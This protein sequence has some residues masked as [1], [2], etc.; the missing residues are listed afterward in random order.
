VHSH[1]IGHDNQAGRKYTFTDDELQYLDDHCVL[2]IH[3]KSTWERRIMLSVAAVS[4]SSGA[5]SYFAQDNYYTASENE[6]AGR[7]AGKGSEALG[8]RGAV[9]KDQFEAILNGVLPTG[10]AVG[11][12]EN[13][14]LA[15]DLTFSMPKSASIMAYVAGDERILAAHMKSVQKAIGFIERNFAEA[16][17]YEKNPKGEPQLTG[18]VVAA[19]FAH[20]TSRALDPQGHIHAIIANLTQDKDGKWRALH[21]GEIWKNNTVIGQAY[22]AAFRA[23]LQKLGYETEAIGKHGSFE[24]KGV[25]IEV[26]EEFSTRSAQIKEKIEALGIKSDYGKDQATLSTRDDKLNVEDK[27]AL[28]QDWKERGAAMGF[29]GKALHQEALSR[30]QEKSGFGESITRVVEHVA[31]RVGRLFKSN[32]P[33]VSSPM[34]AMFMQGDVI[35]AEH[36]TAAAIR[37]LSEREAAFDKSDIKRAALGFQIKGLEVEGVEQRIEVLL[38]E[39][40]LIPGISERADGHFKMVTTPQALKMEQGILDGIDAGRGKGEVIVA[41][42]KVIDAIGA[43]TAERPLNAGQTAAA[44]MILSSGDK[45]TLVQGVAG[46]G[47]STMIN[48]VARIAEGEGKE[49]L[50]LAFQN[51]MVADLKGAA[52]LGEDGTKKGIDAQTIASF[53]N[54]H[55]NGARLGAG[56][57]YEASKM[58]LENKILLVDEASMVSSKDM[59]KLNEIAHGYGI[60]LHYIGD[61]QQLSA[62]EQGKS[63][64]V[65]QE[66]GAPMARMDDNLRQANSPLLLAVAGLTNEGYASAAIRLLDAHGKVSNEG[67]DY[68]G[69]A[70]N[71]WLEKTTEQ[72]EKTAIFTAGRD[73]RAEINRLVQEGLKAEGTLGG[74]PQNI[75]ALQNANYTREEHRFASS[76]QKGLVLDVRMTVKELALKKGEYKVV[77][78]DDKG[79]VTLEKDGKIKIIDPQKINPNHKFD[80]LTLNER[81]KLEIYKGDTIRWTERDKEREIEKSTFAKILDVS[82]KGVTVELDTKKM[83]TLGPNDPMMKR[84]D[85]GYALNAHMAQGITQESAIQAIS[86]YQKNLATQRSE[87]VLAT[88]A[89]TDLHVV[90]DHKE[91]LQKQLDKSPGNKTSALEVTG[92]ITVD[93]GKTIKTEKDGL[94]PVGITDALREKLAAVQTPPDRT[95]TLPVP[96][97]QLGLDL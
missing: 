25:P 82:E 74:S 37:H 40:K 36:A 72:R 23:E 4:S 62:T 44:V 73:D 33:M 29:D 61:R 59:L 93:P 66:H 35:K 64:A 8:L 41:P 79:R 56:P 85:L 45:I 20:D 70:A 34:R 31:E 21:N 27:G 7:W 68:L 54:A 10:E 42:D 22:H 77:S 81:N 15:T 12:T 9:E 1:S 57:R 48:A 18:N 2:A 84:I 39:G 95:N 88:R 80:R 96:Q 43:V 17:T 11:Q 94:P 97:K 87:N 50:G 52:T 67:G 91:D 78:T 26:R 58:V 49:V 24:I 14:K 5:A 19:L 63:Y 71:L 28:V 13:R 30:S 55:H 6:E 16:R 90:T 89:M 51:K 69:K 60:S 86:A 83:L 3:K 32:D 46:A 92:Q 53:V 65:A 75:D 38:K 47:K 76:Y